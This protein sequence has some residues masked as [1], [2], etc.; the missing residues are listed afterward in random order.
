MICKN[1]PCTGG[2]Y[3]KSHCTTPGIGG[4][5]VISVGGV[6]VSKVFKCLC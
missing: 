6:G 3:R 2:M 4:G 1:I 5:I